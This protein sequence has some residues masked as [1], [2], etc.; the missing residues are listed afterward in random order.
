MEPGTLCLARSLPRKDSAPRCWCLSRFLSSRVS[1]PVSTPSSAE[2]ERGV[3][4]VMGMEWLQR[5]EWSD[6]DKA[7]LWSFLLYI[8]YSRTFYILSHTCLHTHILNHHLVKLLPQEGVFL[9]LPWILT[10]LAPHQALLRVN[11]PQFKKKI[12]NRNILLQPAQILQLGTISQVSLAPRNYLASLK[13]LYIWRPC[14]Y[15]SCKELLAF[16]TIQLAGKFL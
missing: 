9:I 1:L 4:V 3:A 5:P 6:A 15:C 14:T 16:Q 10:P 8:K 7:C 13:V 12:C 11:I 2:T